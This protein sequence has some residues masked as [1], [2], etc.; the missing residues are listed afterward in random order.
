MINRLDSLD[1]LQFTFEF[2]KIHQSIEAPIAVED[3]KKMAKFDQ[4]WVKKMESK[5]FLLKTALSTLESLEIYKKDSLLMKFS[6]TDIEV[7]HQSAFF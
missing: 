2:E 1:I 6:E 5:L 7:S 3:M 4:L